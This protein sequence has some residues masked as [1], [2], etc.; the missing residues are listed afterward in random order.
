MRIIDIKALAL[1]AATAMAAF[2]AQTT[3]AQALSQVCINV[4]QLN[5]AF[6]PAGAS[7]TRVVDASGL[8][9]EV[10]TII[11]SGAVAFEISSTTLSSSPR[12]R[13]AALAR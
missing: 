12:R 5:A 2:L 8:A 9:D 10:V 7:S 13:R 6:V 11:W 4:N 3:T 1:I